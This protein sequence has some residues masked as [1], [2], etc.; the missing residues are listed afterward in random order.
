MTD[1]Q[2][3]LDRYRREGSRKALD[4]L[5][6]RHLRLVYSS[7]VRQLR[8]PH[9][10][11]DVT[12]AVFL[13]LMKKADSIRLGVAVGG[14]LLAVTRRACLDAVR[15]RDTRQQ[16]EQRAAAERTE[17]G[18][19]LQQDWVYLRDLIDGAMARL[20]GPDRDAVVLR[21]F[22]DRSAAEVG[23]ELGLSEDAA[24]KRASRALDRLRDILLRQGAVLP[25]GAIGLAIGGYASAETIPATLPGA[26]SAAAGGTAA[27]HVIS[28]MNGTVQVMTLAKI[29][30]AAAIGTAAVVVIGIGSAT[31]TL[32]QQSVPAAV[33]DAAPP[34]QPATQP[35]MLPATLP[36]TRSW[37]FVP[38]ATPTVTT[39]SGAS[40]LDLDAP[41]IV[42]HPPIE[43]PP[44]QGMDREEMR[45][46]AA[47]GKP[48]PPRILEWHDRAIAAERAWQ[49][50][51]GI[52]LWIT[53]SPSPPLPVNKIGVMITG[54]RGLVLAG[55]K[56]HDWDMPNLAA[57]NESLRQ[58]DLQIQQLRVQYP[59]S[60]GPKTAIDPRTGA[61]SSLASNA[62][63]DR[64]TNP[65]SLPHLLQSLA[66]Q[67]D[68]S[69]MGTTFEL[70]QVFYFR[71]AN[72]SAGMLR[73]TK[74]EPTN[75]ATFEIKKLGTYVISDKP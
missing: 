2:Q 75:E 63:E 12:Q 69:L 45:Q 17:A 56:A 71:T 41:A 49:Q 3:L 53:A 29:K 22:E 62:T 38:L 54:Y 47:D 55:V 60:V 70:P 72:G 15:R 39:L 11:E 31:L 66:F 65:N 1:D 43:P 50:R 27:P 18:A 9:L 61:A 73:I 40:P 7:A 4:Q 28:I 59:R 42:G 64:T 16:Y 24:R 36:V 37:E 51:F 46:L 14:W 34:S 58:T 57:M 32:M 44:M 30:F 21:Y 33:A 52:D 19:A 23:A 25:S 13:V 35:A 74:L 48:L 6:Q 10:A 20:S 26:I 8:D 5:I 67:T 68:A